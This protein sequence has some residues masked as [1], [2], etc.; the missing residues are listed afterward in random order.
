MLGLIWIQTVWYPDGIPER[1]FKKELIYWPFQG[2]TS[3]VDPLCFFLSCVWYVFVR[4]CL[5]VLCGHLL[6]KGWPLVSRLWCQTVSLSL[7]HW[8]PGSAVVLDCIDSSVIFAPLLTLEWIKWQKAC[9]ITQHVNSST[10][11]LKGKPWIYCASLT[12]AI[13]CWTMSHA[14]SPLQ[15]S[16]MYPSGYFFDTVTKKK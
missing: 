7:S 2:G 16:V 12:R 5:Y 9:K 13:F 8:Y 6:G 14:K 15:W 3:F 1:S 11:L 10:H 4:V